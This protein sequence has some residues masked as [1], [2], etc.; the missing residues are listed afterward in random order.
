MGARLAAL[1]KK[2]DKENPLVRIKPGVFALR[3]W[4]PA[5]IEKGL[6]D[7]TPALERLA[8]QGF[9]GEPEVVPH[10]EHHGYAINALLDFETPVAMLAHLIVGSEG[11]LGFISEIVLRTA[12]RGAAQA[13]WAPAVRGRRRRVRRGRSLRRVGRARHRVHG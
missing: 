9:S 7:R 12:A 5:M 6:A 11:T 1:V 10:Q 4:D 3:E 8:A 13:H 2:G